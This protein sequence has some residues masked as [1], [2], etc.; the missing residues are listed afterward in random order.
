MINKKTL[1]WYEG[2]VTLETRDALTGKL[3]QRVESKNFAANQVIRYA[4]WL[5]RS[6]YKA[7][8]TSIGSSDTDYPPHTPITALVLTD[9]TLSENAATEWTVPGKLIGYANKSTYAGTDIYRGTPNITQLDAKPTY[10]KWVFDWPTNAANG[11][12]NSVCWVR[13]V[14]LDSGTTGSG[15]YFSTSMTTEQTWTSTG[16]WTFFAR[17]SGSRS[18]GVSGTAS[19]VVSVMDST[20][21]QTTTFNVNGQFSAIQGITWDSSNSFL[22]VIGANGAARRIAAYDSAGVLQTGP[23]ATTTRSYIALAHDGTRL[24]SAVLNSGVSYTMYAIDT[25]NGNDMTNFNFSTYYNTF[26][27][28]TS[29][30]CGL[31]W[32][33]TYSR[34]WVRTDYPVAAAN[35]SNGLGTRAAMYSFDTSG[36]PQT[37]MV[38]LT[39]YTP[40]TG[41]FDNR[42]WPAAS[43]NRRDFDMIDA[44]QFA[45]PLGSTIYRVRADGLATRA[46]LPSPVTKT[47]TQ[48]LKVIYQINYS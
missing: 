44:N 12:I 10:T 19:T 21:S 40:S 41:S 4:K 8:I 47:N 43:A 37:P 38:N 2:K 22:W 31:A 15:P 11:T 1:D 7:G 5:Q 33:S 24:W 20:Y 3:C 13:D 39:S 32:D 42:L 28:Y 34:L 36:N 27:A 30:V 26:Y 45:M 25:T 35:D 9:S 29:G 48:T 46:L 23:F 18:Y 16:G 6:Y 14:Y 17:E